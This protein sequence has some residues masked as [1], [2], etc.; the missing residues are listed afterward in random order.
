[1][2]DVVHKLLLIINTSNEKDIDYNISWIMLQNINKISSM[3][4]NQL[5]DL[6]YVSISTISRFCRKL[7]C[8]SFYEFKNMLVYDDNEYFD[9]RNKSINMNINE[10]ASDLFFMAKKNIDLATETLKT[11]EIDQLVQYI[12]D[13]PSVSLV[14]LNTGQ[15]ITLDFQSELMVLGKFAT[16]FVDIDKQLDNIK[17][18]DENSLLVIF[19]ISGGCSY[20][21]RLSEALKQSKAKKVLIT[22]NPATPLLEY[23]TKVILYGNE[24]FPFVGRYAFLY[25][26]DL[27]LMRYRFLYEV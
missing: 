6:C 2:S 25:V 11:E 10:D 26:K 19:S 21:S 16:V 17:S 20:N 24:Y 13:Y 7:G 18:L 27:I 14:G 4:I 22:Q 3:S 1:M 9:P 5:A 12:H 15:S 8:N 23:V